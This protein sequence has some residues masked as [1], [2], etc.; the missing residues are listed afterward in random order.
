MAMVRGLQ[1]SAQGLDQRFGEASATYLRAVLEAVVQAAVVVPVE[2][3]VLPVLQRF[4]G[5]YVLD[6]TTLSLPTALAAVWAGCG[7]GH[8]A[9]DGAAALKVQVQLE[10]QHGALCGLQLAHGRAQ[11]RSTPLQHSALPPGALRLADL[12]Y[13][14]LDVLA[15]LTGDGVYW[16]TRLQ[17]GTVVYDAQGA[18]LDLPAALVA[19]LPAPA[20]AVVDWP[21]RLGVRAQV[22][23]RL[24]AVRVPPQTAT[25]RRAALQ[26]EAKRQG[27]P[28]SRQR[29]ALADW[30]I[31]VTNV[32]CAQLSVE[33]ALVLARL[34]WQI[35]LLFKLWKSPLQLDVSRSANP[36]RIL[37]EIYAKLLVALFAHWL[38]VLTCWEYPDRSLSKALHTIQAHAAHLA[39]VFDEVAALG[40]VVNRLQRCL[41]HGCRLTKRKQRPST[42]QRLLA[43][44]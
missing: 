30:T 39:S 25:R 13:F 34:R 38:L 7:G 11:D 33:E 42:F 16:L 29:L 15:H 32:P 12:G 20:D 22:A 10:L 35:E 43:L 40:E 28:V 3:V 41:A 1:V 14:S 9:G 2:G 5:V 27:Q 8:T 36:W 31:L 37:C 6:S 18:R 24:L 26:Q 21:V 44:G 19:A 4:R 17:A 23:A